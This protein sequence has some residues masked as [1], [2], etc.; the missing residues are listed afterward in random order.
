[1]ELVHEGKAE[2]K[3]ESADKVSKEMEVFYNPVME[4]NRTIS[5]LLLRSI[6]KKNIQ[7]GL[8][9]SGSGIRGIRFLAELEPD[10]V[11]NVYFNDHNK[12]AVLNIKKNLKRNG[13]KKGFEISNLDANQFLLLATG[14]DYIDIDPFGSPNPYLDCAVKR[15][16]REG[17]IAVTATDTSSLSGTHIKACRRKYWAMPKRNELMHEIGI[18]IL[19]RKCQL[20]GAQ[21][22]KALIP[23]YSYSKDHYMRVFFLCKK[24]KVKVDEMLKSHGQF[25]QSG[26]MYLGRLWDAKVASKLAAFNTDKKFQRFLDIIAG[27]A[28]IDSIGFYHIPTIAKNSRLAN[29]PRQE[30]LITSLRKQGKKAAITHFKDN[31]IRSDALEDEIIRILKQPIA[32]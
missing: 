12:K 25:S 22:D 20:I 18:R 8:P 24:G 10:K 3:I 26:P 29:I 28:Q 31:G 1:M 17:I 16:S 30:K 14:F 9:L 27:E 15:I 13:I 6:G 4:L 11:K 19:I 2:I 5:V 21:Y 7:A 23:I 32:N